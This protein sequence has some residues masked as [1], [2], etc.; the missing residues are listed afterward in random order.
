MV[1]SV[2]IH[3]KDRRMFRAFK[4]VF[5]GRLCQIGVDTNGAD[6]DLLQCGRLIGCATN[7]PL[8]KKR[9]EVFPGTKLH[10]ATEIEKSAVLALCLLGYNE[11]V[12]DAMRTSLVAL[13][14]ALT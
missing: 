12:C 6:K 1:L 14:Y 2:L 9:H 3:V 11:E 10:H 5:V 4:L 13:L 8:N 7:V